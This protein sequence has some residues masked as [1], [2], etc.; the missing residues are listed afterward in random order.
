[1]KRVRK[2]VI[3]AAGLGT[4][5]H[6]LVNSQPKEMLRVGKRPMISYALCEAALC[7]L[8]ELYIVINERKRSLRRYLESEQM[9]ED[10][11]S[12]G[13]R[14]NVSSLRL[15]FVDQ[16][17]PV[18]SGEAIYRVREKIGD[19]PFALMMP[20][21]IFF[22]HTVALGQMIPLYLRFE[23]DTV[24]VLSLE[25]GEAKG[26]GNVG[27][28]EGRELEPGIME[29]RDFSAKVSGPLMVGEDNKILKAVGR[30]I[31][32]PHFFSYLEKTRYRHKEWD[33]TPALQLICEEREVLGK[34]LDGRGF[35]V[36][37]PL[38]YKAAEAFAQ[39]KP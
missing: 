37:N 5:M 21:F 19:E 23:Q 26:F 18:G 38:G 16:P 20:D 36:G 12:V 32:G 3:P 24:G 25:R 33:D 7:G 10:L 6:G 30:W 15:T 28:I 34:I 14:T 2:G 11:H 35:D 9:Q 31:L 17:A 27:I 39:A 1:M 8:E 4:R 22:G 29:I 13:G